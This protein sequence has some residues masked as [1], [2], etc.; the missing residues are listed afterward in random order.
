MILLQQFHII[1]KIL[2]IWSSNLPKWDYRGITWPVSRTRTGVHSKGGWLKFVDRTLRN[3]IKIIIISATAFSNKFYYI[4][5]FYLSFTDP[6]SFT[7]TYRKHQIR[8]DI[9][10]SWSQHQFHLVIWGQFQSWLESKQRWTLSLCRIS[11]TA[12]SLSECILCLWNCM[13]E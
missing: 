9:P 2:Y 5:K 10:G 6:P 3:S 12:F 7:I 8:I 4:I 13:G 11:S 1:V